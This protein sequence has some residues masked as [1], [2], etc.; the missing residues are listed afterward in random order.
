M[1]GVSSLESYTTTLEAIESDWQTFVVRLID[2]R[3]VRL[4]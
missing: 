3:E 1:Y 2:L 4:F